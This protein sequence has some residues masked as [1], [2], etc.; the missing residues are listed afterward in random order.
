MVTDSQK[1]G[2]IRSFRSCSVCVCCF[3]SLLLLFSI[4]FSCIFAFLCCF[5]RCSL[6]CV[7]FFCQKLLENEHLVFVRFFVVF[8]AAPCFALNCFVGQSTRISAN[9]N[10]ELTF[11]AS[12]QAIQEKRKVKRFIFSLHETSLK[13]SSL[14]HQPLQKF[15]LPHA[16]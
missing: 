15:K 1:Y 13:S 5:C 4:I 3:S 8:V 6:F 11:Y 16:A 2:T 12:L 9:T 10:I 7:E 14:H